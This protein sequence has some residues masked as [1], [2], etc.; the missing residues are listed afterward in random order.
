MKIIYF[1]KYLRIYSSFF[2][3]K[4]ILYK[5]KQYNVELHNKE[6]QKTFNIINT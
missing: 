4:L 3:V 5:L 1:S 2:I 6:I